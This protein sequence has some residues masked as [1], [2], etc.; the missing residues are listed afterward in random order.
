MGGGV[1]REVDGPF[2]PTLGRARPVVRAQPPH[3]AV[4]QSISGFVDEQRAHVRAGDLKA[5][6][7]LAEEVYPVA[8]ADVAAG[9]GVA[10]WR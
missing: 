1:R 4:P 10:A 8:A 2:A 6:V 7:T 5:L 9:L 3:L